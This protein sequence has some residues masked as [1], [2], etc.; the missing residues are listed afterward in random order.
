MKARITTAKAMSHPD[1]VAT[2]NAFG[3]LA[4]ELRAERD[5]LAAENRVLREALEYI[6]SENASE[7]VLRRACA[8]LTKEA[9]NG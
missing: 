9:T 7:E 2:L 4:D 5:A 8:A 1:V 3:Q 6:D